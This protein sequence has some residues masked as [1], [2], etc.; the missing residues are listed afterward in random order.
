MSKP[1]LKEI[2]RQYKLM[3]MNEQ[4]IARL[5]DFLK[6]SS[7]FNFGPKPEKTKE[8]N[9][10]SDD[11]EIGSNGKIKHKYSG[12]QGKNVE[13]VID[14]MNKMGITDLDTQIGILSVIAKESGFN[15]VP[16]VGYSNTSNDRIRS[17]FGKRVSK[18]SDR[19]LTRL[20]KS[21]K[22]FFEHVYGVNSGIKLG[23]TEPGDGYK[24]R[25]RGYN[26]LT[27]RANYRKYG[28]LVGENLEGN[29]DL[30][31]DPRI[32]AKVAVQFM[33]KGKSPKSLPKFDNE[34]E[35]SSYFADLN[36]GG[37]SGRAR[38]LAANALDKFEKIA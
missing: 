30:L 4:A 3:G 17:I 9:N 25:G 1:L 32:A 24:Y 31:D 34:R 8:K 29:P 2:N 14:E 15:M 36:A 37:S 13:I 5:A 28:S 11:V 16:E 21:D 6:S 20:K 12:E 18:L 7:M 38:S 35:A 10:T 22:D 27:G 19:Q 26:G 33:L 23:N